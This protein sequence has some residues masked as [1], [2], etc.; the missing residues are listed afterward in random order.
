MNAHIAHDAITVFGEGAPP[1]FVRQAIIGT[2]RGRAGPH[3]VIEKV[4]H[5]LDGRVAVGAHVEIAA[6]VD[7]A[8][9]SE[10]PG[11]DNLLLRVDEVRRALALRADLHHAFVFARGIK[12]G[13]AFTHV[14]ADWL[15]AVHLGAGFNRSE[16]VKRVPMI[17]RTDEHDVEVLRL[18][19]LAVI[20]VGA[21]LF[22]GLLSLAGD[23]DGFGEH[24]LVR[25]A[26]GDDFDGRHLNEAPEVAFAI[27]ARADQPDAPGLA[28]ANVERI[29]AERRHGDRGGRGL[30]KPA[31]GDVEV[32]TGRGVEN[33]GFHVGQYEPRS[34]AVQSPTTS[35]E[36]GETRG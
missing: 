32:G 25:I 29:S 31:S 17:R 11:L 22:P 20:V 19:H 10:Q 21:R 4:G 28:I 7:V 33:G 14:S 9:L 26:D 35:P 24:V 18:E 6:E 3:F 5:R 30:E 16:C 23:L 15:L 1:A 36:A 13:F 12:H 34:K 2:Q 27:P 8:D